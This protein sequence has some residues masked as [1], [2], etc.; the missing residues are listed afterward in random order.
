[1]THTEVFAKVIERLYS[2]KT[3]VMKD[4]I[5]STKVMN[6]ITSTNTLNLDVSKSYIKTLLV[7]EIKNI[8]ELFSRVTN[9]RVENVFINGE[10]Y[11]VIVSKSIASKVEEKALIHTELDEKSLLE[12][13][14]KTFEDDVF[15]QKRLEDIDENKVIK[16]NFFNPRLG[17]SKTL[18]LFKSDIKH[19]EL[20]NTSMI[21][22]PTVIP[23]IILISMSVF[24]RKRL[25][26]LIRQIRGLDMLKYNI[27]DT[28][29]KDAI[30]KLLKSII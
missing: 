9:E 1:M 2:N 19:Q 21:L 28:I 12:T 29:T 5:R 22:L 30:E 13:I 10:I 4:I 3:E 15:V 25:D 8:A 20:F 27:S 6:F 18:L 7:P 14:E 11:N 16:L 24:K 23:S 17:L 26:R